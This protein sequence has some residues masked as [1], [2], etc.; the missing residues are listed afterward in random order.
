MDSLVIVSQIRCQNLPLRLLKK[1]KCRC[2]ISVISPDIKQPDTKTIQ[3]ISTSIHSA[4]CSPEWLNL[5]LPWLKMG[6]NS[7]MVIAIKD[8]GGITPSSKTI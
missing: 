2:Q 7:K 3:L 6:S 8:E 5:T 4:D 1:P